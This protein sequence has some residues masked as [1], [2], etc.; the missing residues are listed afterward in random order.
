VGP[1][2][3]VALQ[4]KKVSFLEIAFWVVTSFLDRMNK[5]KTLLLTER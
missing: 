2:W 5:Y 1:S 3:A 4:K